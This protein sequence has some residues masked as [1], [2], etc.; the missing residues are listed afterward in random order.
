[1]P[2]LELEQEPARYF[3]THH[4]ANDVFARIDAEA[5]EQTAAA[6][7]TV[8]LATANMSGDFGRIPEAERPR[9]KR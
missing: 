3:D 8:A 9:E 5:L 4:T 1:V 2:L 6:F 7:A